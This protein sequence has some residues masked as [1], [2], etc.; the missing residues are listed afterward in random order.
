[1]AWRRPGDKPLSEPMTVRLP[2]HICATQPQWVLTKAKLWGLLIASCLY[3]GHT[4]SAQA[5]SYNKRFGTNDQENGVSYCAIS[6]SN[7]YYRKLILVTLHE[8]YDVLFK[9]KC[10]LTQRAPQSRP[11]WSPSQRASLNMLLTKSRFSGDFK[12]PGVTVIILIPIPF[13][14]RKYKDYV[15]GRC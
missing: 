4:S 5:C 10:R 2:T 15:Y 14:N 12:Y 1:M 8:R 3:N 9:T 7:F 13:M 11:R 6:Q